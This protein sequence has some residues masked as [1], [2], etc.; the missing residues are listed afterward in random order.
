MNLEKSII[1]DH[2]AS[3]NPQKYGRI[4]PTKIIQNYQLERIRNMNI[5]SNN[6]KKEKHVYEYIERYS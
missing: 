1:F 5:L 2:K 6:T 3:Q 4:L